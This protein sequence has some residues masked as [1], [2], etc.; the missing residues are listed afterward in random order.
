MPNLH[1]KIV[2]ELYRSL[3]LLGCGADILGTVGSWGDSLPDG[4]VLAG[5][6]AWNAAHFKELRERIGHCETSCHRP[7]GNP[8]AVQ[9]TPS[10][11]A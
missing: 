1:R 2:A 5:L 11:S 9:G 8:A 10:P 4:D 7:L 3:V 6:Q